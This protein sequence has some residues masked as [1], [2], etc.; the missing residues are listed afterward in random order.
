MDELERLLQNW[1]RW[2]REGSNHRNVSS[3]LVIINRLKLY[4]KGEN[5]E[6]QVEK[7]VSCSSPPPDE[8]DAIR[9][10][11]AFC[12]LP[13]IRV[14]DRQGRDLLRTMYLKPWVS[15]PSACRRVRV[16]T[17]RA[18]NSWRR[19]GKDWGIFLIQN[20]PLPINDNL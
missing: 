10:D 16:S 14:D 15:F 8:A 17:K 19:H 12:Q 3:T 1:G 5:D 2:A 13:S 7:P 20:R 9:V 11:K 4:S 6:E 18:G